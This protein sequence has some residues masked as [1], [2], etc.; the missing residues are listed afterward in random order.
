[1]E[2]GVANLESQAGYVTAIYSKPFA[3]MSES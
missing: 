3:K 1:M 2:A